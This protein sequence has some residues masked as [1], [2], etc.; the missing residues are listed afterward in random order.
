MDIDSLIIKARNI[1]DSL[2]N[3]DEP[4]AVKRNSRKS[5]NAIFR[6]E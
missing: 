5:V 2:R 4:I 6:K 1:F 3:I